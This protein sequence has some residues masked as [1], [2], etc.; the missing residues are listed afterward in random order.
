MSPAPRN[1]SP[2]ATSAATS[3]EGRGPNAVSGPPPGSRGGPASR[4]LSRAAPAEEGFDSSWGWESSGVKGD[5][6]VGFDGAGAAGEAA[7]GGSP[8]GSTGGTGAG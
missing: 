6:A 4:A 8:G 1:L 5:A 7:P 3:A 2:R